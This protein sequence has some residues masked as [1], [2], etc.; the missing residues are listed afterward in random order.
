LLDNICYATKQSSAKDV[1]LF[2]QGKLPS[3][4]SCYDF[5][6]RSINAGQCVS[7]Y[8]PWSYVIITVLPHQVRYLRQYA[9]Q[10]RTADII[11]G[12]KHRSILVLSIPLCY[13]RISLSV[14]R[15]IQH[16]T[17]S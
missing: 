8:G 17:Y 10:I 12:A 9:H 14:S 13:F 7:F 1:T 6:V 11:T 15:R 16:V 5:F 4:R 3:H 2:P